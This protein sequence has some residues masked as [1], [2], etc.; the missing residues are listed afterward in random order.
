MVKEFLSQRGLNY[1]E[2]DVSVNQEYAQE[3]VNRTGQLG[4]PVTI[5]NG[6]A[7]LGFDR[8][9]LEQVLSQE[10][11]P[12]FGAAVADADK[13]PVSNTGV[14]GG[15]YVGKVKPGSLA[16]KMG[17]VTGDI[18]VEVNKQAITTAADLERILSS[19]GKGAWISLVFI[20]GN[21]KRAAEGK[22]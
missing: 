9:R 3:L 19:L 6:E 5:V 10:Q 1:E 13:M 17:L 18:I 2:R 21:N 20:R 22:L 11:R 8:A 12:S 14:K 4:V 7:I 15:A 16:E